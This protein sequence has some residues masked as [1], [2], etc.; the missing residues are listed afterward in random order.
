[1]NFRKSKGK[2]KTSEEILKQVNNCKPDELE[3]L[4]NQIQAKLEKSTDKDGDGDL[5]MA[6]TIIT[7]RLASMRSKNI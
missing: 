1:M 2:E 3:S 5:L 6:K 7:S 4:L